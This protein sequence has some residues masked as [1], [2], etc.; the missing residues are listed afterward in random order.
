[1]AKDNLKY[2]VGMN[3]SSTGLDKLESSINRLSMSVEKMG[4]KTIKNT[5]SMNAAYNKFLKNAQ[6]GAARINWGATGKPGTLGRTISNIASMNLSDFLPSKSFAKT[7]RKIGRGIGKTAGKALGMGAS[8][9]AGLAKSMGAMGGALGGIAGVVVGLLPAALVLIVASSR[10]LQR[11]LGNIM[12]YLLMFLRPIGDMFAVLMYPLMMILRP[13]ALMV[14]TIIR[15]FLI[16]A[17]KS[18]RLSMQLNKQSKTAAAAG[19]FGTAA[20]LSQQADSMFGL[21]LQTLAMGFSK[22]MVNISGEVLKIISNN[23]IDSLF[24]TIGTL[25]GQITLAENGTLQM[26]S[27]L[28]TMNQAA[29]TFVGLG[30]DSAV[31]SFNN[32]ADEFL[33]NVKEKNKNVSD[34]ATYTGNALQKIGELNVDIPKFDT[35]LSSMWASLKT[36]GVAAVEAIQTK[37]DALL[38]KYAPKQE[39]NTQN[40]SSSPNASAFS[41]FN[42][43][44]ANKIDLSYFRTDIDQSSSKLK[45]LQE[46]LANMTNNAVKPVN[47]SM[48]DTHT[49]LG[50]MNEDV[51]LSQ[52]RF[53]NLISTGTDP[54]ALSV[55]ALGDNSVK[56]IQAVDSALSSC[57]NYELSAK[58]Y[59]SSAAKSAS[60]AKSSG[61]IYSGP[62]QNS[63]KAPGMAIGG[64]IDANGMYYLHKGESVTNPVTSSFNN[65]AGGNSGVPAIEFNNCTFGG[66]ADWKKEMDKYFNTQMR[67]IR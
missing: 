53:K 62:N 47:L 12:K 28:A 24:L 48:M 8:S 34:L 1:M 29:K 49:Q 61:A 21:G 57:K 22:V 60:S 59:A 32:Y 52:A 14:N 35:L 26:S 10:M 6:R 31:Q 19:M 17:R 7:G 37:V 9:T 38:A 44:D 5:N 66:V 16:E 33:N 15:P 11:T 58:A 46:N 63:N 54:A 20:A 25:T 42:I 51:I 3:F 4:K 30:I 56:T 23:F 27:A 55:K 2:N 41:Y 13:L 36:N 45:T 50:Y 39:N 67:H 40:Q 43:P 65:S 64:T 18:F